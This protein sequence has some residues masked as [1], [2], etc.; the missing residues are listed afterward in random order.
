MQEVASCIAQVLSDHGSEENLA[1]VRSRVKSLTD[2][3]RC[4]VGKP[5]RWAFESGRLSVHAAAP[6]CH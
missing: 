4:I 6:Y 1:A 3:F 5:T 2:S